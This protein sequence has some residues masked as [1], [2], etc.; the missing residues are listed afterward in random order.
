MS[1]RAA[2][3]TASQPQRLT[4]ARV[5][6]GYFGKD[7][8]R[9]RGRLLGGMGLALIYALARVAEPWP[10][11]IVFDQVLFHKPARG[12]WLTPFTVFGRSSYDLL[13]AAGVALA[14]AALVRGISYYYE[15]Y[16][17]SSAAQEIVYSIRRWLYRHM[18]RMLLAFHQCRSK[19]CILV[20]RAADHVLP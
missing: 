14:A 6:F 13:A 17:L 3:P 19:C 12:F 4:R 2:Q 10:L 1:A 11:K 8:R 18:H 16:L 20:R 7:L 9:R 5:I 15:D